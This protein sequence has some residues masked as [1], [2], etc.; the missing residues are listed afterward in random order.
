MNFNPFENKWVRRLLIFIFFTL[1]ALLNWTRFVTSA[2]AEHEPAK[3][4]Y[5]FIMETTGAYTVLLLLPVVLWFVKK[6]PIQRN[7]YSVRI[8]FHVIASI[9]FG[10]SHTLLMYSSRITI[11]WMAGWGTYDYGRWQ[12]VP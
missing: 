8:P 9:L 12:Y 3:I 4:L 5:Y 2:L 7:N 1:I 10:V 11:F 6:Y